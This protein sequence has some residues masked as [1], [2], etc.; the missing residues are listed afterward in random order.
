M[1]QSGF[2]AVV[3]V[4]VV[5][6]VVVVVEDEEEDEEEDSSL[7]AII[8]CTERERSVPAA[9]RRRRTT[10]VWTTQA[11]LPPPRQRPLPGGYLTRCDTRGTWNTQS[12]PMGLAP[13][14]A[15]ST[16]FA[17]PWTW[18][19]KV[20]RPCTIAPETFVVAELL[21]LHLSRCW[22]RHPSPHCWN[23]DQSRRSRAR[24]PASVPAPQGR[25]VVVKPEEQ[26]TKMY[27]LPNIIDR[28][29]MAA[30]TA[31]LVTP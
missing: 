12:W 22:H 27:Q 15:L 21:R 3:T 7:H 26:T 8:R 18:A 20:A 29:A 10:T 4:V 11:G 5:A 28:V 19:L 31:K 17:M 30:S 6:A 14:I 23:Q 16:T 24:C 2:G 9:S 13:C 1:A 25:S